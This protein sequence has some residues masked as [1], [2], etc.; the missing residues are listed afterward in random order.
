MRLWA[1]ATVCC[2]A[3][4]CGGCEHDPTVLETHPLDVR[5]ATSASYESFYLV[6]S[7]G[8]RIA[9]DVYVP[10]DYPGGRPLPAI[11]EMTRYW[12]NRGDGTPYFVGRALQ[13]GFAWI[14]MDERGTGAS[15]GEWPAPLTDRA[16]RDAW[17]VIEW[18][19]SQPWS[20]GRVGA[21]G[22]SY[23]GMAAQQMAAHAHPALKA[24]V[25]MSDTYDQYEDLL[26]P[27]GMFNEAFM[28]GWSD[29]VFAMDRNA[30]IAVDGESFSQRPVD[31]D[32][33]GELLEAA[34]A[35]HDGNLDVFE[36]VQGVTYR[37]DIV[38]PGITLDD[39]STHSVSDALNESG[40]AVYHWGSW[41]DGGSA[42]GVIRAF[43]ESTGPRRGTIGSWTHDLSSSSFTGDLDRWTARPTSEAQ[44]EEALNFFD[45]ILRTNH[46]LQG[47]IL[48]Y[49]TMGE[50]LWKATS[51]WPIPGTV[52]EKLFLG[53]GGSLGS[54]PPPATTGED[55]YVV[56][57]AVSSAVEPRWLG[58]LFADTWY[59]D[60]TLRDLNLLVYESDPLAE[61]MEVTG[62]PVVHLK[63]SST[64]S[65]GGFFVYLEDVSPADGV[66][67]VTEGIL[68]GIHRRV[69]EEL[70]EW[71]RPTP[72]HSY[73][74]ADAMPMI[75]GEVVELAFGMEPTSFLFKK[76]HRIRIAI[77]GH[78][79]SAFRRVPSHGIPE[80]RVQRNSANPSWI[81]LPVIR[82]PS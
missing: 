34:I 46:P 8:V 78:D 68:R 65:D 28:Q 47:R 12:R 9:L 76:G 31:A 3:L 14:V 30:S 73:R 20:N 75:P 15:F 42:D 39:I 51:T 13:R 21:T 40:V 26:F 5:G 67:Y 45:E 33:S 79:D 1:A 43:M 41:M 16:L 18:I 70:S 11:L 58:P 61:D 72:Y 50:G 71:K 82:D 19:V 60:R 66:T 64:H 36:A 80:L 59:P 29:V 2:A 4:V 53:E 49:Y 35:G 63:L 81:E 52:T 62:Y 6:M 25:P 23:P 48:R 77:A 17:E 44:W 27:G 54:S 55:L 22:V 37:D 74:S 69:T 7:D 56:D 10:E 57:F 32:P 24:I 38:T